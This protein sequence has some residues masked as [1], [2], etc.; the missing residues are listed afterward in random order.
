MYKYTY[1]TRGLSI[2]NQP[3]D[4]TDFEQEEYEY[5]TI[6]YD[7]KLTAE[8]IE[9]YELIDLNEKVGEIKMEKEKAVVQLI[10]EDG[11][12]FA[13]MGKVTKALKKNGQAEL[14]PQYMTEAMSGGY[15]NLLMVTMKYVD[16]Q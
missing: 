15:N 6:Y 5:E 16:V 4:F 2:G 10:G 14:V 13:I 1:R 8:E 7:R 3:K 11:N 9:E 12:A